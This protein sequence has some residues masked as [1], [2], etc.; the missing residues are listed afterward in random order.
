MQF[1]Q[2]IPICIL[3]SSAT[4]HAPNLL[5][6]ETCFCVKVFGGALFHDIWVTANVKNYTHQNLEK[7]KYGRQNCEIVNCEMWN[8]CFQSSTF[9]VA[10]L[11]DTCVLPSAMILLVGRFL[12][13]LTTSSGGRHCNPGWW[14]LFS[15]SRWHLD[16]CP[17]L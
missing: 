17:F 6:H 4:Q 2:R 12:K 15:D 8:F 7:L 9:K 11:N 14:A 5:Y 10:I 16:V 1:D 13:T 3:G